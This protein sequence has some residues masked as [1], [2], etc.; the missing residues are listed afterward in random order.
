MSRNGGS[1]PVIEELPD[2][3]SDDGSTIRVTAY[4]NGQQGAEVVLYEVRGGGHTEP[5]LSQHYG[6]VYRRIV[7]PQN[8]DIEM[9]EVVWRFFQRHHR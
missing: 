2:V 8:H 3:D 7:G 6:W 1:S 9:A 5:S 4:A